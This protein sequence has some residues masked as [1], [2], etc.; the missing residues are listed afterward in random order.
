MVEKCSSDMIG[1]CAMD[2]MDR[3]IRTLSTRGTHLSEDTLR[4]IV[5]TVKEYQTKFLAVKDAVE[6]EAKNA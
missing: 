4:E 1:L 2:A 5:Y 6:R 3:I